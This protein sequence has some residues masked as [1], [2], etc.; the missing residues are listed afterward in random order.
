MYR[1]AGLARPIEILLVE[2]NAAD[3]RLVIE[4][5][6][7]TQMMHHVHTAAD[8]VQAIDFVRQQGQFELAPLPDLILLD[9]NLPRMSGHEVLADIKANP[10]TRRIPVIVLTSSNDRRD[11]EKVYDL[12]ANS[13][14][15]KPTDLD[16][17]FQMLQSVESFWLNWA[18]LPAPACYL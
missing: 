2:D 9:L 1:S 10:R 8:G 11:V 7:S 14:I 4:G 16:S 18:V 12:N 5:L 13:Y 17:M 15:Q 6:K 3:V